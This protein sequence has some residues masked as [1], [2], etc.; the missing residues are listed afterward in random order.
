MIVQIVKI[1][2][3]SFEKVQFYS[4]KREEMPYSEYRDFLI[5]MQQKAQ[6]IDD[7][8]LLNNYIN[9]IGREYGADFKHFKAE[10]NAER[11]PPPYHFVEGDYGVRLYC[12]RVATNIVIL[13]N[14]DHKTAQ[15]VQD[16]PNCFPHFSFA[17]RAANAFWKAIEGG[18]LEIEDREIIY[19][20]DDFELEI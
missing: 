12:I 2:N 3:L 16:C 7:L 8:Q 20:N 13:L 6:I 5:R 1:P 19:S 4:L 11:L 17:N 14:G 18:L 15:K 9:L 10:G